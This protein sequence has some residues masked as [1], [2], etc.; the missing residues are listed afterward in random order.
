[1]ARSTTLLAVESSCDESALALLQG[2]DDGVVV[3]GECIASQ[4]DLHA[5]FG[6]VVPEVAARE[7][8][9]TL[10]ALLDRLLADVGCDLS[11]VGAVAVTAGPGLL[12]AL[13]VGVSWARGVAAACGVPL[14]PVHHLEG[15][16]LAAGLAGRLPLPSVTL[17]VSG[18]HTLLVR[19]DGIGRYRLLG[20]TLDDAAGECFDKC[21]RML[22]LGYPGG[23]AIAAAA[24]GGDGCRFAL[25]RPMLRKP[26]LD[27]SFSGLKTAVSYLLRDRPALRDDPAAVADLAASI[28]QAIA[29]V[30]A[31]RAL[32]ACTGEG[33]DDLV[34]AGG[35][36][37]N[38]RLRAML[39]A[40]CAARG[41]TL[42]LPE[43]R[44]CTDN[45]AM[46]GYAAWRRLQAGLPVP[47]RDDWDARARWPLCGGPAPHGGGRR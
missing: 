43:V 25:P 24:A 7:H 37:A 14:I 5:R 35:V 39:G 8:L 21:A 33:I 1:M 6:G 36:A 34:V 4:I 30:L 31:G 19:V 16:L 29:E 10:P 46:I 11:S 42:H 27:F 28:E 15:H 17:L 12:G 22:G 38:R 47:P 26:G 3:R 41:I 23:P 9:R 13:L 45:A 20:Q 18:G 40:G 2:R 44:H 32:A